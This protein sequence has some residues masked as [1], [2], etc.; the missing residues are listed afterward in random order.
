MGFEPGVVRGRP[1]DLPVVLRARI[2]LVA[3]P[4]ASRQSATKGAGRGSSEWM[5]IATSA[6]SRSPK[7]ACE[8]ARPG[9]SVARA[10]KL[11]LLARSPPAPAHLSPVERL[12][13]PA[14][15]P[16]AVEREFGR[17]K[18]EWAMS[19]LRVRGLDR[20][21]PHADLTIPRQARPRRCQDAGDRSRRNIRIGW[22]PNRPLRP[23]SVGGCHVARDTSRPTG[24]RASSWLCS[25]SSAWSLSRCSS[26]GS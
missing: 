19:P 10:T 3:S 13:R 26:L 6:R 25:H 16:W 15:G 20:V 4:P 12:E 23:Q 11:R 18:N 9:G 8:C 21:R 14:S 7:Q 22:P 1:C 5:C 17:L 24:L 2:R